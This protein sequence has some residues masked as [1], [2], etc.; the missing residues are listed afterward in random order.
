M[1]YIL[2]D[3]PMGYAYE[4]GYGS[5]F[6]S[7]PHHRSSHCSATQSMEDP[8]TQ[9]HTLWGA[10]VGGP[11]LKD[12]HVDETGDYIY[13]EVTDTTQ[14]SAAI[15]QVF[16]ISTVQRARSLKRKII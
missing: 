5:N 1:E 4:V 16:T 13:N 12:V 15:L 6:A 9:V 14:A 2:G 3:N 10:L 11:D 8:I 7:Q